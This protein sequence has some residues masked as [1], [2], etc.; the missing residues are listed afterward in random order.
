MPVFTYKA[1]DLQGEIVKGSIEGNDMSFVY[2]SISSA[3]LYI[4]NVRKSNRFIRSVINKF[5]DWGI[6]SRDI[7]EFANNF[8]IMLRAGLPLLTSLGDIAGATE[9]R[10][11]RRRILDI[12]RMIELGSSL[13]GALSLHKDI[14]SEVFIQL[15]SVGEETGQLDKSLSDVAV[16]LQRMEDLRSAIKRALMYP[17]FAVIATMGAL[18]FWLIYVLPQVTGFFKEMG[19]KIPAITQALIS[20]SNFIST[21]WYVFVLAP[22]LISIVLKL[23]SEREATRYYIDMVKL[24]IPVVKLIVFNRLQALFAEQLRIMLQA[25][26]TIDRSFDI[27]IKV[28][29]NAVFKRALQ[30]V[31]EEILQGSRIHEA[32]RKHAIFPNL[33][34]RLITIGEETGNLTEQLNYLSEEF[35]KRLNDISQRIEKLIEPIVIMVIGVIFL[36]IIAGLFLPIYELVSKLGAVR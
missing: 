10:S 24:K 26:L 21:K 22:L 18:V 32:I 12:K 9:N 15:V 23:M 19:I 20:T 2:D 36:I 33:V 1:I 27:M 31:K 35:I 29:N 6:K 34:T 8:S 11:F 4:L 28:I 17:A 25:G 14:F 16:H 5:R 13:S 3:G 7:I 30:V